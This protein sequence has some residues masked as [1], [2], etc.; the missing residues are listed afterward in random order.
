VASLKRAAIAPRRRPIKEVPVT[1]QEIVGEAITQLFDRRDLSAVTRWWSPEYVEHSAWGQNGLDGLRDA[2]SSLP[3]GF[4]HE[5][6]RVLAE[7]DLV[8]AQGLYYGVDS[9]PVVG[10]DLWRVQDGQ[11]AEHWDARQPLVGP[12][13]SGHTMID[14]PTKVTQPEK[15]SENRTIVNSFLKNIM[16]GADRSLL[17]TFFDGDQFIQHN[18]LIAD[19]LSG[20]GAA[21]QS[22]VWAATVER[23]HHIV[24]D[25]EFVFT[26]GEGVLKGKRTA[27]FDIFRVEGGR[28]V[29]HW[30]VVYT[31]PD[32]VPHSNG[33]F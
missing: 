29:E 9:G 2:A 33:A 1:T 11:I 22:G 8:V 31:V 18:P 27:F 32:K 19:G 28:L 16:M 5:R 7:G 21:I 23:G 20:L 24:A 15:T 17:P 13:P 4:R 14:G 30:D 10:C 25:G 3:A 12:T 26:Q 6:Y